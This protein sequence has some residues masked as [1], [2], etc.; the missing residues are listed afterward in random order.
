[1]EEPQVGRCTG[2]EYLGQA[3][4]AAVRDPRCAENPPVLLIRFTRRTV[5][6]DNPRFL[7]T[8]VINSVDQNG[9]QPQLLQPRRPPASA[10]RGNC[11]ISPIGP[12]AGFEP[13]VGFQKDA[14]GLE[15]EME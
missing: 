9:A 8:D 2:G 14:G 6:A 7:L 4:Q 5:T 11:A 13:T 3:C 1:M 15:L 12:P 10:P